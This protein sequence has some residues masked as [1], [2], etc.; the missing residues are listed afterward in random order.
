MDSVEGMIP[1][2]PTPMQARAITRRSGVPENADAADPA[3]N[4]A[5]PERKIHFLP[6]LSPRLPSTRRRPANTTAYASTVHCSWL[7]VARKRRTIVG[8]ATLRTVV[9]RLITKRLTHSTARTIQRLTPAT[10]SVA[11]PGGLVAARR[12]CPCSR[13][14]MGQVSDSGPPHL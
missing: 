14:V 13:R 10:A 11:V 4:T 3:A 2:A 7:E 9:S 5:S 12:S 8:I 1:A 6:T